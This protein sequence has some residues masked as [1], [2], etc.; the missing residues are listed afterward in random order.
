MSDTVDQ[1]YF[2]ELAGKDPAEV[3]RRALC[4][5]DPSSEAYLLGVWGEHYRINP[6]NSSII[7]KS[8]LQPG[9]NILLGLFI[10][11]YLLH[12]KE[13]EV[14]GEW[15]S[16][17]EVPG[18]AAFFRGPHTIPGYLIAERYGDHLGEFK[19]KCLELGGSPL[20][21]ADA[22]FAFSITPRIPVAVLLWEG[23]TEF[24]AEAKLLFDRTI[25]EQLPPDVIFSLA[26]EICNRLGNRSFVERDQERT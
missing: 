24:P 1:S 4:N 2:V 5:Y 6:H 20:E 22:A 12:I 14:S 15:I 7:R 11:Y 25:A 18:G 9:V 8:A 16:E 17:K 19:K 3:C 10:I 26:V 21:M 23:D 13:T